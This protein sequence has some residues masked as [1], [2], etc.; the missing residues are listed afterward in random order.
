LNL[1]T[2]QTVYYTGDAESGFTIYIHFLGNATNINIYNITTREKMTINTDLFSAIVGSPITVGDDII[3]STVKGS[4]FMYLLRNGEQINILN[5]LDR[6]S[7]WPQ[8][9]KGDNIF[10]YT[11]DYGVSVMQFKIRNQILYEGV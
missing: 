10:A 7:D 8:L 9:V 3:I 5:C 4:K 1:N 2:T 6:N 11:A